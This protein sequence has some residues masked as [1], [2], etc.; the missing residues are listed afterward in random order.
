VAEQLVARELQAAGRLR[1]QLQGRR[2]LGGRRLGARVWAVGKAAGSVDGM[3]ALQRCHRSPPPPSH[4]LLLAVGA[5]ATPV[6]LRLPLPLTATAGDGDRPAAGPG[7]RGCQQRGN[8]GLVCAAIVANLRMATRRCS[9]ATRSHSRNGCASGG[10]ITSTGRLSLLWRTSVRAHPPPAACERRPGGRSPLRHA[11]RCH[12]ACRHHAHPLP[13][14]K[15]HPINRPPPPLIP[16]RTAPLVPRCRTPATRAEG[17]ATN[18][19]T[20]P[21]RCGHERHCEQVCRG[22]VGGATY[23]L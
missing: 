11:A 16:A 19:V 4:V 8:G 1:R 14:S 10:H 20:P 5:G 23:G 17:A 15:A 9:G 18:S 22:G 21:R 6:L 12:P 2:R 7:R 3:Q 13:A